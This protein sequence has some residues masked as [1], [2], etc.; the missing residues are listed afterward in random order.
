MRLLAGIFLLLGLGL[1]VIGTATAEQAD[2][3]GE[4][5]CQNPLN[6]SDQIYTV[7]GFPPLTGAIKTTDMFTR[8]FYDLYPE[9]SFTGKEGCNIA[10]YLFGVGSFR[11]V[12]CY[13]SI[14]YIVFVMTVAY[15]AD[16]GGCE[17]FNDEK[18][19]RIRPGGDRT[20]AVSVDDE[21]L[22]IKACYIIEGKLTRFHLVQKIRGKEVEEM[23]PVAS[24]NIVSYLEQLDALP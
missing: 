18:A 12:Y 21:D 7:K 15:R 20:L 19:R 16:P 10:V 17:D 23:I 1:G 24:R 9:K 5:D 6:C 14:E 13:S 8:L 11:K 2:G 3:T 4:A 22:V